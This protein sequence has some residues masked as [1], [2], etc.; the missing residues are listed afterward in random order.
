MRILTGI[1]NLNKKDNWETPPDLFQKACDYFAVSP[2]LD[3]C[4]TEKNTKC[5]YYYSERSLERPYEVDFFCNPPYSQVKKW[6]KK[7]YF[8]HIK[9][10]VNGIMLIFAKTDTKAWHEFLF[11]H[12]DIL[13]LQGRVHFFDDGKESINPAPYPS[14]L[15][16]FRKK[17]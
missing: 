8:E 4:A 6:I 10:N 1:I 14:A 2:L 5:K 13:F 11:P 16:C 17:L 9:Y 12:A 3:V 7:C 15:I